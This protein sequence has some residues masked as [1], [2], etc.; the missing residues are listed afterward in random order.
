MT[1]LEK[2]GPST[3]SLSGESQEEIYDYGSE[4]AG[5][6][7]VESTLP[8]LPPSY[9]DSMPS[10]SAR[11]SS[12]RAAGLISSNFVSISQSNDKVVG[13]WYIDTN[14]QPPESLLRPLADGQTER[15]NLYLHSNNGAIKAEVTLTGNTAQRASI[16]VSTWNGKVEV[17]VI[18]RVNSQPFKLKATTRNGEV[19]ITLPVDFVGPLK[20]H[21]KNGRIKFAEDLQ[22][23]TSVFTDGTAFV[24]DW[25][26]AGFVDFAKW[27]G[28]EVEVETANGKIQFLYA[29]D[30]P[31]DPLKERRGSPPAPGAKLRKG[32]GF[33]GRR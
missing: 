11:A 33:F 21:T 31:R 16:E 22:L 32:G 17:G 10:P 1:I 6:P 15:P 5:Y 4:K 25:Q 30:L 27:E 24:G 28:D 14:L 9:A 12:S 3:A 23:V 29:E 13:H 26:A 2:Q 7:G 19:I 20:Y 8:P 18:S